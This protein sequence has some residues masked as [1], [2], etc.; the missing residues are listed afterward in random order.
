MISMFKE[1]LLII[2]C[3]QKYMSM[4]LPMQL[5]RMIIKHSKVYY[6]TNDL[7]F[8]ILDP[9]IN[10]SLLFLFLF[11]FTCKDTLFNALINIAKEFGDS[12]D[13]G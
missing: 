9:T 5:S 11:F 2:W 1:G 13:R 3:S 8:D 7:Y 4:T 6:T 10:S 12:F